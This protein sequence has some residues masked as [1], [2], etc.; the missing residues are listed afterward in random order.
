M[1]FSSQSCGDSEKIDFG[2]LSAV[3][4]DIRNR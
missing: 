1:I 4:L 3:I 2:T